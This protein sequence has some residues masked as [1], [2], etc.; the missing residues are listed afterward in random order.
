MTAPNVT[1]D[2]VRTVFVQLNT[3]GTIR[4]NVTA[5]WVNIT[6]ADRDFVND[7]VASILAYAKKTAAAEETR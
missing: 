4:L 1:D 2:W 7:M 3:G 6:D 5:D